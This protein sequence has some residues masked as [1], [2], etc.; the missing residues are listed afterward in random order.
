MRK[1]VFIKLYSRACHKDS[2]Y[3]EPNTSFIRK[4]SHLID[5]KEKQPSVKF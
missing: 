5:E 3:I 4:M 1:D 2:I